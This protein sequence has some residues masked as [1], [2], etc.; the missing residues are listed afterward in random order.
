M[1]SFS[2]IAFLFFSSGIAF[3]QIANDDL[4]IF[5]YGNE[6]EILKKNKVETVTI[7]LMFSDGSESSKSVNY[8]NEEGYLEKQVIKSRNGEV[9]REFHFKLNSHNDLIS[10]IQRT[11]NTIGSTRLYTLNITKTI[12]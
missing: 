2:I 6:R 1:K 9:L 5:G 3:G 8:F 7:K 10:R 11:M 12:T 4:S